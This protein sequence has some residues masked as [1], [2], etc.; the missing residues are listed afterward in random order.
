METIDEK[1]KEFAGHIAEKL[2]ER[3]RKRGDSF[4][5]DVD[6]VRESI[7]HLLKKENWTPNETKETPS[8]G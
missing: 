1:R 3:L 8:N 2:L 7:E 5:N 6:A 4:Y